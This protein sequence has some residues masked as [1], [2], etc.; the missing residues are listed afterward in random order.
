MKKIILTVLMSLITL[1]A[2]CDESLLSSCHKTYPLA[3]D[4]LYLLTLSALNSTGQYEVLEMQTKNGYILFKAANKSYI[5]TIS[6]ET[7]STSGIKILPSNSD[8]S[9]GTYVQKTIFDTIEA[10]LKNT[11]EKLL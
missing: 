9:G 6:K 2:Y 3:A 8:F 4:K 10:N 1:G 11:P 5:A 7:T